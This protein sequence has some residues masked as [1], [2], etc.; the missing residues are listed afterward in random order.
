VCVFMYR[1]MCIHVY[2]CVDFDIYRYGI[3]L[4]ILPRV[5]RT[6]AVALLPVCVC[7]CVR[8]REKERER[9]RECM[10]VCVYV[11]T[12]VHMYIHMCDI[13]TYRCGTL[14]RILPRAL[15]TPTVALS[16]VCVC[17]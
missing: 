12:C 17:A 2:I 14:L 4:R 9:E 3:L 5:L 15:R 1:H 16:L 7:V 11:Y 10:C 8:V 6:P 13:D